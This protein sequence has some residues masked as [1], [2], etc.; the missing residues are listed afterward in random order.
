MELPVV[1][2][3]ERSVYLP[4][5]LWVWGPCYVRGPLFKIISLGATRN[6][7]RALEWAVNPV[8]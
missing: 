2:E 6:P 7:L 4:L 3:F 8:G 5:R 1:V